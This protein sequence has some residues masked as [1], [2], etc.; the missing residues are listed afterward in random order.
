MELEAYPTMI[1]QSRIQT[2]FSSYP[3]RIYKKGEIFIQSGDMPAAHYLSSGLVTQYD[4]ARN[5]NKLALNIYKPGTF[6]SL[7]SILNDIPS[8][9]FFEASEDTTLHVA[10]AKDVVR[11]LKDNPDVVYDALA[12]LSRGGN[13]LMLRLARAMEGSAEDRILQ[14]LA[15]MRSRF[16]PGSNEISVTDTELATKTGLARETV[17]RTLKKLNDQG[18]IHSRRGKITLSD[19]Y[20]I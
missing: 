10:P 7:A 6:I 12:R 15:I 17:S 1:V 8:E 9:F 13:G 14:E 18:V 20:H 3:T 11:F 5:G 2:F 4:I 19:N 16:Y